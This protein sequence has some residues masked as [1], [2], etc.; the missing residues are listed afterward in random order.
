MTGPKLEPLL[1]FQDIKT[2]ANYSTGH[3]DKINSCDG[4]IINIKLQFLLSNQNSSRDHH[5]LFTFSYKM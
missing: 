1:V 5:I 4:N 3:Q 2:W